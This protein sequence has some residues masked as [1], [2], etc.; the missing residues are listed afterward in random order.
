M[1]NSDV[2]EGADPADPALLAAQPPN[3]LLVQPPPGIGGKG[4]YRAFYTAQSKDPHQGN[5][6]AVMAE[7]EVALG[8]PGLGSPAL[9]NPA[10]GNPALFTPQ[11]LATQ[12]YQSG[13]QGCNMS[14]VLHCRPDHAPAE[15]PGY[16]NVYHPR[17]SHFAP[18]IGMLPTPWGDIAFAFQGDVV[19]Q[20]A[21]PSIVW[22]Q[23][24][25]H[26]VVPMIRVPTVVM[27]DQL[28][29]QDPNSQ[30]M[31]PCGEEDAGTEVIRT[32]CATVVPHGYV[33]LLLVQSLTPHEA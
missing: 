4:N 17:V 24:Y 15:A 18:R 20:Q 11:Q 7:F 23:S 3:P 8:N 13:D 27:M 26:T 1:H 29:G 12:V 16:V 30:F 14:F 5:Y 6:R 31:G 9:G 22:D 19:Q 25:F 2:Q 28:L 32:R 33:Q 10:L 21:P